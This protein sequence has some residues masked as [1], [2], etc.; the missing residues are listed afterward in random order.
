MF[1]NQ[2][3]PARTNAYRDASLKNLTT[4]ELVLRFSDWLICQRYSRTTLT[5][6]NRVVRKFCAFWGGRKLSSVTHL[7]VRAFLIDVSKRDLS[8]D[9][10]H[11]YIWALR[12]FF[13]FLCR[14]G[15]VDDVAPRLVRPR[16][17]AKP[18]PKTLSEVKV[19]RLIQAAAK[20]RDRAIF[21]LDDSTSH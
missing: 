3:R 4:K 1:K 6:Y 17:V 14:G 15:V 8:A 12:C 13:D 16:P 7:D 18:L 11:R 20:P 21:G 2:Y 10:M 5:T 9:I 19:K